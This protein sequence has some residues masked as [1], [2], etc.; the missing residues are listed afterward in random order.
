M[1]AVDDIVS[2][3]RALSNAQNVEGMKRFAA[4]G[5]NTLGISIPSLRKMAKEI[6]RNHGT[7]LALWQTDIHEARILASMVDDP[8]VVTEQQMEAW[9]AGFDSWDVTDQVCMNLFEK[10][11]LAW[12]K[13]I[14]WA[15]RSEEF[16]KRAG[17]ALMACLGWHD[18]KSPASRFEP[19]FP[20]IEEESD[21]GRNF[22]RKAI[23]WALRNMGKR[24]QT[25]REL[26]VGSA[27]RIETRGSKAARWVARDVLKELIGVTSEVD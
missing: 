8:S 16:Q 12:T 15:R 1:L 21:D 18:K 14:E 2:R 13:A 26:A 23:S 19:F 17:F 7:A 6:G 27:K 10:T 11:P 24:D 4:G 9:V 25:L 22:V 3:L 5:K 20:V